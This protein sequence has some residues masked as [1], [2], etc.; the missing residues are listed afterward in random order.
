MKGIL[1]D[2][3]FKKDNDVKVEFQVNIAQLK[4][5]CYVSFPQIVNSLIKVTI[6]Q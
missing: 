4:M 1:G 5:L 2:Y 6:T 3:D